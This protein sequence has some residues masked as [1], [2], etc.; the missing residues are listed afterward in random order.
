[1]VLH[2][3]F[4]SVKENN[5]P[6]MLYIGEKWLYVSNTFVQNYY[7]SVDSWGNNLCENSSYIIPYG[8]VVSLRD[9]VHCHNYQITYQ[10]SKRCI[11]DRRNIFGV[12][13]TIFFLNLNITFNTVSNLVDI[14]SITIFKYFKEIY[15]YYLKRGFRIKTLHVDV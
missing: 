4:Y 1:M 12:W 5:S 15:M 2:R 9:R 8:D 14:K 6:Y 11:Y 3:F 7:I 10:T 13:N